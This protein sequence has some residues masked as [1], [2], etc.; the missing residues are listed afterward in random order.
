[1]CFDWSMKN[2]VYFTD[3]CGIK[4]KSDVTADTTD[5]VG[6]PDKKQ[7]VEESVKESADVASNGDAEAKA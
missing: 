3:V 4:R 2:L 5:A 7:K 1:M 6:K